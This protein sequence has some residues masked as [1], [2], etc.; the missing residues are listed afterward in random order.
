MT[1]GG[2]IGSRSVEVAA[3]RAAVRDYEPRRGPTLRQSVAVFVAV[4]E[5]LGV[6]PT[7]REF[8][9]AL[10][11]VSSS[12]AYETL[13]ALQSWGWVRHVGSLSRSAVPTDEGRRVA[14]GFARSVGY[15]LTPRG[16]RA[17]DEER[18]AA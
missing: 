4:H 5:R 1:R 9:S 11:E 14:A 3:V 2:A 6:P 10:G 8:A 12:R 7:L 17:F 15:D 16:R 18:G 13:A